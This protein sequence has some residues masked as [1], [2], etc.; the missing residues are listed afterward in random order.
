MTPSLTDQRCVCPSQPSRFFP[1]NSLMVFDSPLCGG[2]RGV[3]FVSLSAAP[4][5]D[6]DRSRASPA[7]TRRAENR[8]RFMAWLRAGMVDLRP[9]YHPPCDEA[10]R[11][12]AE[13]GG[14]VR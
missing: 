14:A 1:L 10:M 3:S 11:L 5:V 7:T 4:P 8:V 9:R 6:S 12:L 2:M 13:I